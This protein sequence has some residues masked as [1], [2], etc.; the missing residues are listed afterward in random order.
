MGINV[1]GEDG[2][3]PACETGV[4]PW[5]TTVGQGDGQF[6]RTK[7]IFIEKYESKALYKIFIKSMNANSDDAS[8]TMQEIK[9]YSLYPIKICKLSTITDHK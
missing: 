8:S 9:T 3:K 4:S 5:R 2:N 7:I 1:K 6:N